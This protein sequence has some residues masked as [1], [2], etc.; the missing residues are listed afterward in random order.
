MTV[1]FGAQRGVSP[2][3]PGS[4][5]D[6]RAVRLFDPLDNLIDIGVTGD[7]VAQQALAVTV[8]R[9]RL[10]PEHPAQ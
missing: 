1:W 2:F 3:L 4:P 10:L 6:G 8:R 9:E 7:G 5:C